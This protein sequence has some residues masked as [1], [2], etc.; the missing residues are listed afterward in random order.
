LRLAGR[1][2]AE[3]GYYFVTICVH[4]RQELFGRVVSDSVELNELGQIATTCWELIPHIFAGVEPGS[5]VVMPNHLHG[6]VL[7]PTSL[8]ER[9]VAQVSLSTVVGNFKT[10][11]T[12]QSNLPPLWQRSFYDRVVRDQEELKLIREYILLNPLRWAGDRYNPSAMRI[13][14]SLLLRDK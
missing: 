2:Y 12:R 3:P 7:L 8:P 14:D 13:E 4:G 6:L 9:P 10:A 11:V 5:F 1:D